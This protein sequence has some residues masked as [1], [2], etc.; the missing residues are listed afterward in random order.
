MTTRQSFL[1]VTLTLPETRDQFLTHVETFIIFF[2]GVGEKII[3]MEGARRFTS[4]I[5]ILIF[6]SL[7]SS[8]FLFFNFII[9]IFLFYYIIIIDFFHVN[10]NNNNNNNCYYYY[11]YFS[12][13]SFLSFSPTLQMCWWLWAGLGLEENEKSSVNE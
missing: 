2:F 8:L 12:P 9:I 3:E 1:V 6:Q 13:C 10:N 5:I 7:C 11:Y 4:F